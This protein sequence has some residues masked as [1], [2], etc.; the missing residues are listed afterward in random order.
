MGTSIEE[1]GITRRVAELMAKYDQMNLTR[2]ELLHLSARL[3]VL[4]DAAADG[5]ANRRQR[6]T[7]RAKKGADALHSKP[8]GNREKTQQMRELWA[9][10]KFSSRDACAEQECAALDMSF[11][12]ARKSL[13]CTPKP[14]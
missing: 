3:M 2:E 6:Q 7:A 14:T 4:A 11:S 10:G 12:A 1:D 13:R 8:G 9:S 5:S